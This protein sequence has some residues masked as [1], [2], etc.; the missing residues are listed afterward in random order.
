MPRPPRTTTTSTS[1]KSDDWPDIRYAKKSQEEEEKDQHAAKG[2]GKGKLQQ[3]T[4]GQISGF[5]AKKK[6]WT[7]KPQ[8]KFVPPHLN[9]D[10]ETK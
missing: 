4:R 1:R 10:A 6:E 2:K 5:N 3:M 9:K 7:K 8:L